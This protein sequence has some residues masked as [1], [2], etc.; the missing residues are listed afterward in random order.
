M[1]E[2]FRLK[3][4]EDEQIHK[5]SRGEKEPQEARGDICPRGCLNK[6]GAHKVCILLGMTG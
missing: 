4:T 5:W 3:A 1:S 2:Q 6:R